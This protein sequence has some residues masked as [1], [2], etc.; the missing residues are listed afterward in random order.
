MAQGCRLASVETDTFGIL[1]RLP[2]VRRESGREAMIGRSK[3]LVAIVSATLGPCAANELEVT[4]RVD[5]D[6]NIVFVM[7]PIDGE[8]D[9]GDSAIFRTVRRSEEGVYGAWDSRTYTD[10]S[11]L[12]YRGVE[13]DFLYGYGANPPGTSNKRTQVF[14]PAKSTFKLRPVIGERGWACDPK[15]GSHFWTKKCHWREVAIEYSALLTCLNRR[16]AEMWKAAMTAGDDAPGFDDLAPSV[17]YAN[18]A[19]QVWADIW[20]RGGFTTIGDL[21]APPVCVARVLCFGYVLPIPCPRAATLRP[22]VP[23]KVPSSCVSLSEVVKP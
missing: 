5:T 12:P 18:D 23:L 10:L 16:G 19:R 3:G 17:R 15:Y 9:P 1:G 22:S 14:L 8:R 6:A 11:E 4:F 21:V 20:T 7:W 2:A 13:V